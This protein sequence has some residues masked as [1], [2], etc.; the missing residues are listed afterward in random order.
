M[1]DEC[2]NNF[3]RLRF[4]EER[5]SSSGLEISVVIGQ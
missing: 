1:N 2:I 3:D 5:D 4:Y